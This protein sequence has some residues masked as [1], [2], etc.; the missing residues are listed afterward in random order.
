MGDDTDEPGLPG[1]APVLPA[2]G[3][4]DLSLDELAR[5]QFR[6]GQTTGQTREQHARALAIR[7]ARI[8]NETYSRIVSVLSPPW[9]VRKKLGKSGK[10]YTLKDIQANTLRTNKAIN[11]AK[12]KAARET[13]RTRNTTRATERTIFGGWRGGIPG[14]GGV[15]TRRSGI[16]AGNPVRDALT[17]IWLG[18]VL[19]ADAAR[20]RLST[21]TNRRGAL[22]TR[23][24]PTRSG[25]NR[26][27]SLAQRPT[28]GTT[29]NAGRTAAPATAP[30]TRSTRELPTR[31][32]PVESEASRE[33]RRAM[34]RTRQEL[35]TASTTARRTGVQQQSGMFVRT[36]GMFPRLTA[37]RLLPRTAARAAT[38]RLARVVGSSST[39]LEQPALSFGQS[40]TP[41]N[42]SGVG[43][44]T[45]DAKCECPK[46]KKAKKKEFACS[47]PLVSR[48]V[49]K[50]GIITIKRKLQCPPSKP[51][52]P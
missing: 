41:L 13:I 18:R 12:A 46:P 40:L 28:I 48:S 29:A 24:L 33:A 16:D 3:R 31:S 38:P 25:T 17:E 35:P 32:D 6:R 30:A 19:D 7:N 21:A 23:N 10:L 45:A 39:I 44:R 4:E 27:G 2:P 34:E 26:R 47:N 43:S 49:S 50:D 37:A 9:M 51:K 1:W 8:V 20:K 15:V 11:N 36:G 14:I 42:M 22:A 5:M 52:E